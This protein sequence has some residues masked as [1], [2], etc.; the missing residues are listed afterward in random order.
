MWVVVVLLLIILLAADIKIEDPSCADLQ[1]M[2]D[3]RKFLG[4]CEYL[5]CN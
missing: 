2:L 5:S 1:N 4:M 3:V